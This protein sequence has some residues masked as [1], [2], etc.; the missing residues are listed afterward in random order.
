MIKFSDKK[1]SF[2][3][4]W[5]FV[6][7]VSRVVAKK[8]EEQQTKIIFFSLTWTFETP[9]QWF[10]PAMARR[11]PRRIFIT[12]Q[13]GINNSIAIAAQWFCLQPCI[14]QCRST[15]ILIVNVQ[16]VLC[17][18]WFSNQLTFWT[19][20]GI[21]YKFDRLFDTFV[22]ECLTHFQFKLKIKKEE[23]MSK[24]KIKN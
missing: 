14:F 4:P 13:I 11:N 9:F 10:S 8:E 22:Q 6:R 17:F 15:T 12:R 19:S 1:L 2:I 3:W 23:K 16:I 18:C 20:F 21:D 5:N 7:I 24:L